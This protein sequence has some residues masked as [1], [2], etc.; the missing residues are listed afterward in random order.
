M[1]P[2][3]ADAAIALGPRCSTMQ[4]V[5]ERDHRLRRAREHHRQ[6]QR[7]Q[8]AE[9]GGPRRHGRNHAAVAADRARIR[10]WRK[11]S[12]RSSSSTGHEVARLE[13]GE[14]LL[15]EG[16]HHEARARAVLPRGRRGRAARRRAP[17]DDPEALRQRR[18]GASRST[19]S[20]RRRSGRRGSTS[21]RSRFRRGARR[22]D[23]RQQR[24]RSSSTSS[25][26]AASISTRTRCAARTWIGPTSCASIS[27][28]CR[29]SPWPQIVEVARVAREVLDEV[30]LVGWPKT[31]GSR[32]AHVWVR[33]EP[34]W[35]FSDGAPRR[36]RVRARGRAPRARRSRPRSGGRRSATACSSTT[37]RTRAIARPPART[38]CAPTPDARV[39]MPLSWDDF[40]AC[41][42][43][44]FTLRTVPAMFAARGDAHAG[45]RRRRRAR[46]TRCSSSPTA[47]RPRA[48]PM[49]RGRRTSRRPRARRRACAV[50]RAKARRRAG[51]PKLPV[52]TIAQAKQKADALAGL[53]RWKARH[54]G[55]VAQ[56][57]PEDVLVDT[58][59]GR[60]TAWYRVRI[61]LKNVPPRPSTRRRSRRIRTTTRGRSTR[62]TS[63]TGTG[64]ARPVISWP[65]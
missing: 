61:N 48:S 18:R 17:A 6:R 3:V 40:F 39:S 8:R 1:R 19:R 32:G 43:L 63:P 10:A 24:A 26:S 13:P 31:S 2:P 58:N 64:S 9:R 15:P 47:R 20:A 54:P 60:A 21:R 29:A 37:T 49:R 51:A 14:G 46:S 42:P 35:P 27:I 16:R 53:E 30:G 4:R 25:T 23:R 38:R 56:L 36:A 62:P 7:E 22:R 28:R 59:R 34:R 12:R 44:D 57:A 65:R 11:P 55:V 5:G 52:L 41:D 50:A 33:I 45:D